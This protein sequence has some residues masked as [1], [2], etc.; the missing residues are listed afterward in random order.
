MVMSTGWPVVTY[1]LDMYHGLGCVFG[2]RDTV[3][4]LRE[5]LVV[6]AT[7]QI[8]RICI[9]PVISSLLCFNKCALLTNE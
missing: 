1:S 3:P 8:H 7:I 6:E 9:C 4:G 5:L 2:P